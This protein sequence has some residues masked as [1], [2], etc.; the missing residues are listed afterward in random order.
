V[1]SLRTSLDSTGRR[2]AD[3]CFRDA[4]RKCSRRCAPVLVFVQLER[5]DDD[6]SDAR[7]DVSSP[8]VLDMAALKS[9]A[10]AAIVMPAVFAF[11]D[12]VIGQPQTSIF[13]AFGSF[14]MLVLAEFRGPP[15]TRFL[16][17]L[18]LGCVG[19]TFIT[20]GTLSSRSPWLGAAA[21][22]VVGF[23]TLFV[24][25]FSGY[26]SAA[27]TAAILT[28]VLPV[29]IPAA[30]STIPDRLAGW[31]LATGGAICAVML[32]WPLRRSAEL[33]REAA[34]AVRSVAEV[35]DADAEHL[36]ERASLARGAV[37]GLGRRL[38]DSQH[39]PTGP[40]GPMAALASLPDEL[41]WLLSFLSP[42]AEPAVLELA[43]AEDEE[44]MATAAAV[45][46]TSAE[47]LEGRDVRPDFVRLDAARDAVAR[48][49]VRR[50]PELPPDTPAGDVPA[51]LGPPFRIRAATYSAGQ[52]AGYALRATGEDAPE[53]AEPELGGQPA[54]AA[55]EATEHLAREHASLGSVW[56]QNS[57]R[58]AAGLAVAVYIAQRTG[59]Q[60]G[61]WVVLGTLSVLRSNAL[62]TGWSILSA[63]A[64]TAVGIVVGALLVIGIGTHEAVLWSVLPLAVLLAAYAPRAI[65]FAAGQAGFTVVLFILFNLIQPVGWR[66]GLVR[67]EDVAIGFAISLGVGL[68]FWPRGAAARL[69]KDLAAAYARGADYV[70]A[71]AR[72]LIEGTVSEEA[73]GASR[74]ADAA[75]HRLDD[76]FR[77]YLAERSA[78]TVNVEHV[79]ALVGGASRVR[80]G[81]QSLSALGR[82]VEGDTRLERCG[83]NLDRELHALQSWYGALGDALVNG[84]RVPPPHIRDAEAGTR[85]LACV[86]E[87][88]RGRD[89]ATV[90]AALVLLWSSQHLENL[91]RLEAHLGER[92]NATR[93]T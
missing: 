73:V 65:S 40:T 53:L 35:M 85:L 31:G 62:G 21:M 34:G 12:K 30:N 57:L 26:F 39:R 33:Q 54:R 84:R 4:M 15:L 48:A 86:R 81:A 83:R 52:V 19:A 82:M 43:C 24:G 10:R 89:K 51:A 61:F 47:R 7:S 76:A 38:L 28:F 63:L 75:V 29:T 64:G 58:G 46:R 1:L 17:Y 20:L 66:V 42:E 11:A 72:Q 25:A 87:A 79:A 80:R 8:T 90:N 32:L 18:G 74:A 71:T 70:V 56:F 59:V 14:A 92:A 68:L 41:D 60:H 49:L 13:A 16:A 27:A 37:D 45:L 55:L 88:A 6:H 23:A 67:V 3:A 69:R 91:W 9:A 78:T 36:A 93:A 50:L 5:E 2:S 44:A 77:Q 22:A